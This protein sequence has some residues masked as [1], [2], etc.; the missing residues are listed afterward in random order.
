MP[1]VDDAQ[2]YP[3]ILRRII[4]EGL[5]QY[6]EDNTQAWLMQQDGSYVLANPG[7]E[8]LVSAQLGLLERLATEHRTRITLLAAS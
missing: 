2:R 1:F 6:L 5:T 3:N 4:N 7:E 8:R